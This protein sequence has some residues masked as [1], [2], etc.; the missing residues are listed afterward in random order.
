MHLYAHIMY[1]QLIVI[2]IKSDVRRIEWTG[3]GLRS[4]LMKLEDRMVRSIAL[5]KGFVVLRSDFTDMGV[6]DSQITRLLNKLIARGFIQR[7]SHGTFVKTRLNKFT[8]ELTPSASLEV[9]A[10]ELFQKLKVDVLPSN[11]LVE[12]NTGLTTQIPPGGESSKTQRPQNK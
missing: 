2:I 5:R 1:M 11:G 8:G 6:S 12:Y 4:H 9:V 7:V 3:I 10:K